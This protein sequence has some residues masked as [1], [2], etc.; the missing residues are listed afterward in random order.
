V[1]I[2]LVDDDPALRKTLRLTLESMNHQLT[3]ASDSAAADQHLERG[4]FDVALL[5]LRLGQENGLE[6][7][8][9][10]LQRAP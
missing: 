5:D 10:L 3:E 4:H 2:L 7:L 8:P 9:K 1:H 6:V